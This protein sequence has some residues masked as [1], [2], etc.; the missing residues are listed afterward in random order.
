MYH[1][2]RQTLALYAPSFGDTL[3]VTRKPLPGAAEERGHAPWRC[4]RR[5]WCVPI[6]ATAAMEEVTQATPA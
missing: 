5:A 6:D 2:L 4:R 1:T 3:R